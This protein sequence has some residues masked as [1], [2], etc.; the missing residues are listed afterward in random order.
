MPGNAVPLLDPTVPWHLNCLFVVFG[1][2]L[3]FIMFGFLYL[4][5]LLLHFVGSRA[6]GPA[7]FDSSAAFG[8]EPIIPGFALSDLF[9]YIVPLV[10]IVSLVYICYKLLFDDEAPA[11]STGS[12]FDTAFGSAFSRLQCNFI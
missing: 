3:L 1:L 5:H 12:G 2:V 9:G 7:A 10:L 11:F 8:A 4:M 6:G